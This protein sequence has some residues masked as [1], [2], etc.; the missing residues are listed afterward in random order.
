MH[1]PQDI[2]YTICQYDHSLLAYYFYHQKKSIHDSDCTMNLA[3]YAV[4]NDQLKL[5]KYIISKIYIKPSSLEHLF[6]CAVY[7]NSISIVQYL[8][9]TFNSNLYSDFL[10][11]LISFCK[12]ERFDDIRLCITQSFKHVD[13]IVKE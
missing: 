7:C 1:L 3:K 8:Y 4:V 9:T 5:L 10:R 6:Q 2:L 13:I 12:I 11:P